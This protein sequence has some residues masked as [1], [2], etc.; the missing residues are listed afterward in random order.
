[1]T[2][3]LY[4]EKGWVRTWF[5]HDSNVIHV[6]WYNYTSRVHLR[7][8]CEMQLEAMRKYKAT[9]I[10][11]D[12]SDAIGIPFPQDQEWFATTLYPRSRELGLA[13]II[14]ILP[15][16]V[17]ARSGAKTWNDTGRKNGLVYIEVNSEEEAKLTLQQLDNQIT[18]N[19]NG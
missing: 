1:M 3:E 17:I 9:I 15:K 6:K 8:S 13:A 7:K 10:I 4:T 18:K 16:N 5:D 12:A 19:K 14:S 11:A 2:T